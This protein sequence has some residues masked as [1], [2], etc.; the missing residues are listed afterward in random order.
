MRLFQA[1]RIV[2]NISREPVVVLVVVVF[3]AILA[4][5]AWGVYKKEA[6]AETHADSAVR[7]RDMLRAREAGLLLNVGQLETDEG[8][9]RALREL[10]QVA[11]PGERVVVVSASQE[12]GPLDEAQNAS[13]SARSAKKP[14]SEFVRGLLGF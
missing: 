4:R 11:R 10:Y 5:G 6:L 2:R 13:N 3:V 12:P 8:V 9:E 1:V 14:F 7:E